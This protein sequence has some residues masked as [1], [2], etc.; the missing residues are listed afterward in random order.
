MS[1]G[2][3]DLARNLC[4]SPRSSPARELGDVLLAPP[5]PDNFCKTVCMK[6]IAAHYS[7]PLFS[8]DSL[9]PLSYF[10]TYF[11]LLI[12]S[13]GSI[14]LYSPRPTK[15][16]HYLVFYYSPTILL[17]F[18]RQDFSVIQHKH[19]HPSSRKLQIESHYLDGRLPKKTPK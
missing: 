16:Q 3:G 14:P 8:R 11:Y 1:K 13:S 7:Q 15:I 4:S 17:P 18:N 2:G 9:P 6:S 10:F 5:R 12:N 19:T